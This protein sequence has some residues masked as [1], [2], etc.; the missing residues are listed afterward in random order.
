MAIG[1]ISSTTIYERAKAAYKE[2]NVGEAEVLLRRAMELDHEC[3]QYRT[4]YAWIQAERAGIPHLTPG[5]ISEHY[6]WPIRLLDQVLRMDPDYQHA[7]YYRGVLL[8]RSGHLDRA[9][10]DFQRVLALNPRHI[11]AA[12]E[13]RLH[14]MRAARRRDSGVLSAIFS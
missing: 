2:G 10:A 12:R 1:A 4:L 8:R 11:D 7:R 3:L 5:Q 9:L 6:Q 14:E 13:I